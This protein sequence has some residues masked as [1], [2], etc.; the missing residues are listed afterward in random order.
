MLV[1]MGAFVKYLNSA[2]VTE[3]KNMVV[4][5][6]ISIYL[7]TGVVEGGDIDT[8]K[9]KESVELV[10]IKAIVVYSLKRLQAK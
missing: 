5:K 8:D 2:T 10:T 6:M 7:I 3:P 4:P 1:F 9:G